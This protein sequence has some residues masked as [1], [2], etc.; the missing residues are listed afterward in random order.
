MLISLINLS[1]MTKNKQ[2]IVLFLV[3]DKQTKIVAC[4]NEQVTAF[5]STDREKMADGL[6]G[7]KSC[8]WTWICPTEEGAE[9]IRDMFQ[10]HRIFM[11]QK[12][13]REGELELITYFVSEAPEYSHEPEEFDKWFDGKY[14]KKTGR[15]CFV[16]TEIYETEAGLHHH[17][18][19]SAV[20]ARDSA[21][22]EMFEMHNIELRTFQQMDIF[23]SLWD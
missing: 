11:E 22:K 18:I 15:T 2:S 7:K 6:A 16:L 17:H 12:S 4:F 21:F 8:T 10:N 13:Q 1:L 19:E 23:Q 9:A 3:V 14:P 5:K 20:F